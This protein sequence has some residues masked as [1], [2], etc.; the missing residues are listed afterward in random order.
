MIFL[1]LCSIFVSKAYNDLKGTLITH[2][3][4]C[5]KTCACFVIAENVRIF[6]ISNNN[7]SCLSLGFY[8]TFVNEPKKGWV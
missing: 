6:A 8:V 3:P 1:Y 4:V 5:D 2:S 7:I